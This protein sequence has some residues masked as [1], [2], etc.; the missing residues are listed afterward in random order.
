MYNWA[1][2]LTKNVFLILPPTSMIECVTKL[3]PRINF[4]KYMSISWRLTRNFIIYGLTNIAS[5]MKFRN[6]GL[7]EH[8]WNEKTRNACKMFAYGIPRMK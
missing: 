4:Q 7:I 5:I 8:V 1:Y 2:Y 6:I 3:I